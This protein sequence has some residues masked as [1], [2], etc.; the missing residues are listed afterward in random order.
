MLHRSVY[1][2]DLLVGHAMAYVGVEALPGGHRALHG[3]VRASA[4][5]LYRALSSLAADVVARIARGAD[6]S[7]LPTPCRSPPSWASPY[8]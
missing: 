7:R 3:P 8:S 6:S 4:P 2:A 5:L 1:V